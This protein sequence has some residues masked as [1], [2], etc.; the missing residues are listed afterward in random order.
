MSKRFRVM[1]LDLAVVIRGQQTYQNRG[2]S[3]LVSDGG[4]GNDEIFE[5]PV[6]RTAMII[7]ILIPLSS[8]QSEGARRKLLFVLAQILLVSSICLDDIFI[9]FITEIVGH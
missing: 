4:L 7:C 3:F 8:A 1:K 9:S 6:M 5:P 2:C